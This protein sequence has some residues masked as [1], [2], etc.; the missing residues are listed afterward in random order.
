MLGTQTFDGREWFE[1]PG[2]R[3][4]SSNW[5]QVFMVMP[6]ALL[7]VLAVV[8]TMGSGSWLPFLAI[9]SVVTPAAIVMLVLNWRCR[10]LARSD[11][12]LV[13][14][15]LRSFVVEREEIQR[16]AAHR[17]LDWP[18]LLFAG[19]WMGWAPTFTSLSVELK[20]GD[21]IR[22]RSHAGLARPATRLVE[23]LNDWLS[24]PAP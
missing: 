15:R 19:A 5:T 1:I 8:F 10:L 6:I 24:A 21:V 4:Q 3:L 22:L 16:F 13:V 2:S 11:A 23:N 17:G 9:M 18:N 20:S 14:G 12:L 7:S